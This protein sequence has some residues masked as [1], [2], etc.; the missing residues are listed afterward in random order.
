[1]G[2]VAGIILLVCGG[3]GAVVG[4]LIGIVLATLRSGRE[5]G[6]LI[7]LSSV[8]LGIIG[9]IGYGFL[10]PVAELMDNMNVR[11]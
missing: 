1:M 3:V 4:G 2:M 11:W 5:G 9:G 10:F 8:V 6:W 7:F